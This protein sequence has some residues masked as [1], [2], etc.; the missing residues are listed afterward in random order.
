MNMVSDETSRRVCPRKIRDLR[1]VETSFE[2]VAKPPKSHFAL[3]AHDELHRKSRQHVAVEKRRVDAAADDWHVR[4][5]IAHL[6]D[7]VDR[8][9]P[10][11]RS[12]PDSNKVRCRQIVIERLQASRAM[13]NQICDDNVMPFSFEDGPQTVNAQ[14]RTLPEGVYADDS[15]APVDD[16]HNRR[17]NEEDFHEMRG[18]LV[19]SPRGSQHNYVRRIESCNDGVTPSV[20]RR[21]AREL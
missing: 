5:T 2:G 7:D 9:R 13:K 1:H 14:R 15:K 8:G 12:G 10:R 19:S 4:S 3:P 21:T 18:I 17:G 11:H 20:D 6:P 16:I